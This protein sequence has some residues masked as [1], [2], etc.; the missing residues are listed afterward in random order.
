MTE[1]GVAGR[2]YRVCPEM[3]GIFEQPALSWRF[4]PAWRRKSVSCKAQIALPVFVLRL[5]AGLF[6]LAVSSNV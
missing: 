4:T 6:S 1:F 2:F 3:T 5:L